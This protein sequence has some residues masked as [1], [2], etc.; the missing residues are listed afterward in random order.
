MGLKKIKEG[1]DCEYKFSPTNASR[2][3]QNCKKYRPTD[4]LRGICYEYEV[5]PYGGCKHFEARD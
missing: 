3:C 5:V 2:C 1:L 4:S